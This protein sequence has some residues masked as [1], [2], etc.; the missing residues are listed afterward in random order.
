MVLLTQTFRQSGDPT[1]SRMLDEL[2][3]G[4]VSHEA[5]Q[6]LVAARRTDLRNGLGIE[7]TRLFPT[8]A[9]VDREKP[10]DWFPSQG[11][12]DVLQLTELGEPAPEAEGGAAAPSSHPF[13]VLADSIVGNIGEWKRW[14]DHEQPEDYPFPGGLSDALS[15]FEQMLVYRCLRIDRITV[16]V[17]RYVISSM[18]EKFVQPPVLDYAQIYKQSN[19]MTPIVFVLSP[20]ADPAFDVFKLGEELG[21]KPGAKLKY[22]A[23]GQGMGTFVAGMLGLVGRL[24]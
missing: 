6:K 5:C 11:W 12:K 24:S 21:Y 7:P 17:T 14:Y 3:R 4:V 22:M 8:N 16:A 1:F 15:S 19:A 18:G 9:E 23:L 2:R 13:T 20:G 10:A